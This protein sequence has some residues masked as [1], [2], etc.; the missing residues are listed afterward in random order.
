MATK[1][2]TAKSLGNAHAGALAIM[3]I[4]NTIDFSIDKADALDVI[5]AIDVG[6][7][8]IV[9]KVLVE[10]ETVEGGT[11]TFD[12]GDG[13]DP[14]GYLDA[15]NGNSAGMTG[16]ALALTEGAPNTVS[17]YSN[18]KLYTAADTIDL[19]MDNAADA[20]VVKV[21]ALIARMG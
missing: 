18:G 15:V 10:V 21:S 3:L 6:A 2:L 8:D 4:S 11:L 16:T 13:T 9:L 7:G 19:V 1:N 14:N 12:V 5:E 17:A 20:A